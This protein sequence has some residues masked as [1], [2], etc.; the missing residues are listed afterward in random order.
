LQFCRSRNSLGTRP[1]V[2]NKRAS[3]HSATNAQRSCDFP[4]KIAVTCPAL[5]VVGTLIRHT[6]SRLDPEAVRLAKMCCLSLTAYLSK[7]KLARQENTI[8]AGRCDGDR[9]G[10]ISAQ[11][12]H[13]CYL[14]QLVPSFRYWFSHSVSRSCGQ[15][16][17]QRRRCRESRRPS[18]CW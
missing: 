13:P 6:K 10:Y 2:A 18:N 1:A 14:T 11:G 9:V 3:H 4:E 16:S 7:S 8:H 12:A 5:P 15:S 17:L